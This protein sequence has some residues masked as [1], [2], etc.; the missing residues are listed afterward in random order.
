[1][2]GMAL[3][4][5]HSLITSLTSFFCL[6]LPHENVNLADAAATDRQ[7]SHAVEEEGEESVKIIFEKINHFLKSVRAK[8]TGEAPSLH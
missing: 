4:L 1:M 7:S 6:F 2:T 8:L 3:D 5:S